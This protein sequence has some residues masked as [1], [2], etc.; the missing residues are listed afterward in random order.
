MPLPRLSA[1]RAFGA[2][3]LLLLFL[4]ASRDAGAAPARWIKLEADSFVVLSDA[5][6]PAVRDAAVRYAAFRRAFGELFVEPGSALPPSVLLLFRTE[7]AFQKHVPEAKGPRSRMVNYNV[8]VDGT[9]LLSLALA[10]NRDEAM[11]MT[12]EFDTIWM[13]NRMGYAVPAWLSQGAGEVL[14]GLTLKKGRCL[15]DN[16]ER[17]FRDQYPWPQF[18]QIG[19]SSKAYNDP[20]ELPDFLSQAIGLMHWVLLKDEHTRARVS[21]LAVRLRTEPAVTALEGVMGVPMDQWTKSI[22]QHLSR[23][24]GREVPF[25]EAAERARLRISPAPEAEVLATTANLLAGWGETMR[26]DALLDQALTLAPSL[27]AVQEAN[28]RRM[29]RRDRPEEALRLYREAITAGTTNFAAYLRSAEA[30]LNDSM[31]GGMD[32]VGEGGPQSELAAGEI[33]QAI[34]LNPGSSEAYRLLGRAFWVLPKVGDAELAELSRGPVLG[35]RGSAVRYYRSLLYSRLGRNAE[36]DTDL[37]AIIADP[38][39]DPRNRQI[40]QQRLGSEQ[41]R[42]HTA[43]VDGLVRQQKFAEARAVIQ[44]AGAAAEDDRTREA[45]DRIARAIDEQ[46]AWT[47]LVDLQTASSWPEISVAAEKFVM[48]FPKSRLVGP[49]KRLAK[50]AAAQAAQPQ[51]SAPAA[52]GDPE[53]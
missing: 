29:L 26:A 32:R 9:P 27:P 37:R 53:S 15:I 22:R 46:E 45:C 4:A 47:H 39:T 6:E 30:R 31:S 36:A 20:N 50:A 43:E 28:A 2:I 5:P 21:A 52:S 35:E 14:R 11:A 19:E 34:K 23:S 41:L 17:G 49:A 25:D 42:R 12:F 33:R 44:A 51:R 38:Q 16:Q 40:A 48:E 13:L 18:L 8:D 10:G 1:P 3:L 24:S 7:R